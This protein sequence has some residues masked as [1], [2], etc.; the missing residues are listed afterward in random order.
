MYWKNNFI[1]E[2]SGEQILRKMVGTQTDR[3]TDRQTDGQT[4]R[5]T[6]RQ[7]SRRQWFCTT[8]HFERL[9]ET[10][11]RSCF[12]IFF[13]NFGQ[14]WCLNWV[15]LLLTLNIYLPSCC[16]CNS[17]SDFTCWDISVTEVVLGTSVSEVVVLFKHLLPGSHQSF[18]SLGHST[19]GRYEPKIFFRKIFSN[20]LKMLWKV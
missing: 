7:T 9:I 17:G 1:S 18:D 11:G 3:Q 10:T 15:F 19:E 20:N 13:V 5:Q 12:V 14:I 16:A 4:D 8:L 6:D 2:K